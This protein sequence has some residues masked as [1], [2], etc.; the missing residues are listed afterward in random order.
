MPNSKSD[1]GSK[2][3]TARRRLRLE[4]I[5]N[6]IQTLKFLTLPELSQRPNLTT[7]LE[8]WRIAFGASRRRKVR[9]P[10]GTMPRNFSFRREDTRG[11]NAKTFQRTVPQRRYRLSEN[12]QIFEFE[13]SR[14]VRVKRWCKRPPRRAQAERHGKP[15]RVQSQ[16]GNSRSGSLQREAIRRVPGMAA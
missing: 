14:Q 8:E 2:C 3:K 6:H 1:N 16:I 10:Q 15:H 5:F 11:R 13:N 7:I 4:E 9:T 12:F